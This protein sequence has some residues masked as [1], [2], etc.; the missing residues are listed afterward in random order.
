MLELE[1]KTCDVDK[2]KNVSFFH[3]LIFQKKG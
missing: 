1:M 3:H 2:Y